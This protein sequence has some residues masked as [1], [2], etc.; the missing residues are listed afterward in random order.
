M[1]VGEGRVE[2]RQE[3]MVRDGTLQ[4]S[5]NNSSGVPFHNKKNRYNFNVC[6]FMKT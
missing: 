6:F 4:L 2:G 1:Y 3:R 5:K